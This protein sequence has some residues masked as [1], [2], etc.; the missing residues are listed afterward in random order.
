[1][2]P[3]QTSVSEAVIE[4][5]DVELLASVTNW[6]AQ[7]V[8]LQLPL[9]LTKKAETAYRQEPRPITFLENT[10]FSTEIDLPT[11]LVEGNYLVRIHLVRFNEVLATKEDLIFV[12]KV[13][14]EQ[15]VNYLAFEKPEIYGFLA[16]FLAIILGWIASI[17]F[18]RKAYWKIK[19]FDLYKI[20]IL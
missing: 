16:I 7:L 10:L 1:M 19:D 3:G 2:S 12:K 9:A 11:D 5:G 18:N 6:D 13:G 14:L 15:W 17:I 20:F 8:I 4:L